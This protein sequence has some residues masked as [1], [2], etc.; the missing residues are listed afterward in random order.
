ML[1]KL[2]NLT[3]CNEEERSKILD[4]CFE[5]NE[6]FH[7]KGDK[8]SS[9][10]A[11]THRIPLVEGTVP[12]NTKPYRLPYHQKENLENEVRKLLDDNVIRPSSSPWCSPI[13]LV[14]KKPDA[15]G[16]RKWRMCIDFR[17][18]NSKTISDAYPIPN[19]TDILDQL[20]KS[21][22]FSSLDLERGYW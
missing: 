9:T 10:N 6:V 22:Y 18:V 21:S 4:I 19:I 20:G 14:P 15:E 7:I 17:N 13:L 11:T 2:I 12:I 1:K 3:H 5:Y 8:L 16:K